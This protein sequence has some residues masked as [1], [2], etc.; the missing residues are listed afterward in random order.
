MAK[1]VGARLAPE[2][3][4]PVPQEGQLSG[5][6]IEGMVGRAWRR[7]MLAGADTVTRH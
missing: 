5:A 4:P 6:D 1:K 7:S 2:D 3:I